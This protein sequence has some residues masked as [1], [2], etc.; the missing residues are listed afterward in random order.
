MNFLFPRKRH[1]WR[2][3]PA[4]DTIVLEIDCS[5]SEIL[6]PS[7][8]KPKKRRKPDCILWEKSKDGETIYNNVSFSFSSIDS[9]EVEHLK[10]PIDYFRHYFD[11]DILNV[12]VEHQI[13]TAFKRIQTNI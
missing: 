2:G 7:C 5:T 13:Y 10:L 8:I 6:A 1:E 4:D 3:T 9:A 12:I 11:N